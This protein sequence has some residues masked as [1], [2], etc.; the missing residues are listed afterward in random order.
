VTINDTPPQA[1]LSGVEDGGVTA[2]N[3]TLKGLKTGDVVEV[4]K[5]GKLISVTDVAT[6]NNV[7]EIKSGGTYKIII[8]GV[9]GA[10][11]EYNFTRKQIANAPTSIFI[12]VACGLAIAGITIGLLYHTRLKNDAE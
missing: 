10:K 3:V 7:P 11:I 1:T 12:I 4:Y 2:R 5:D 8:K 9:S 6:S